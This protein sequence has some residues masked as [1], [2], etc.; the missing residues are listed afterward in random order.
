[1]LVKQTPKGLYGAKASS[2]LQYKLVVASRAPT[3]LQLATF[4]QVKH[5]LKTQQGR[6]LILWRR[7][8]ATY[9]VVGAERQL[10]RLE[11]CP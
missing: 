1:M 9:S 3:N 10:S 6:Q 5:L 7:N 11:A 8:C 2:R 4:D